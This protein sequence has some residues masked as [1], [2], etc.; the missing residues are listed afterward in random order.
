M[1]T[2]TSSNLKYYNVSR[3]LS[4]SSD[5]EVGSKEWYQ[6][7]KKAGY[8]FAYRWINSDNEWQFFATNQA[9]ATEG[10]AELFASEK[11][12]DIA[13]ARKYFYDQI[14]I[15]DIDQIIKEWF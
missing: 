13:H 4:I 9:R 2:N 3:S 10:A 15:Y 5:I 6:A 1:N 14:D 7:I 12:C 8:K 11:K